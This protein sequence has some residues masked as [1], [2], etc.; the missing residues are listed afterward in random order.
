M[1]K[2]EGSKERGATGTNQVE[3]RTWDKDKYERRARDRLEHGDEFVDGEK[4]KAAI[5]NK[6]EFRGAT[7]GAAGPAG[8][9]RAFLQSRGACVRSRSVSPRES[10][11]RAAERSRRRLAATR[12]GV[13]TDGAR[14][15][16]RREDAARRG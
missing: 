2:D 4:E 3:R 7:A 13:A 6:E 5:R 16:S 12:R 8:S 9:A 11:R 1:P 14:P 10:R 15:R